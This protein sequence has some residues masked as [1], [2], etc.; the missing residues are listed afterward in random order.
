MGLW[1]LTFGFGFTYPSK[2]MHD[3]WPSN[4]KKD[5]GTAGE[6]AICRSG[7]RRRLLI[8][9]SNK[10][11][12]RGNTGLSNLDDRD[13]DDAKDNGNVEGTKRVCDQLCPSSRR[14]SRRR[15]VWL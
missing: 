9:E 5:S 13:A 14:R 4:H 15:G 10:A 11:D 7:I 1:A 8:A 12:A 6:V 2:G 3:P